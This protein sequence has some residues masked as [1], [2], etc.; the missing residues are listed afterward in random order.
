MSIYATLWR[1]KFPRHGD[2]YTGCGWIDV[3][4]QALPAHIGTPTP[5]YGYESGDP[6][7][8]F[9]PPAIQIETEADEARFRAVV[10][11]AAGTE[12]GTPR[13]PQEYASPLLVLPGTEYATLSFDALHE[14]LCAA[15]RPGPPL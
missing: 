6:Y 8:E 1:L 11:V 10:F 3:M 14:M 7:S 2:D 4:A 12:K 15:L 9:L 5:G 13:S